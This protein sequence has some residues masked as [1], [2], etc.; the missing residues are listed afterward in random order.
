[1]HTYKNV[2]ERVNAINFAEELASVYFDRS[3]IPICTFSL[4]L[5]CILHKGV[6]YK[7]FSCCLSTSNDLIVVQKGSTLKSIQEFNGWAYFFSGPSFN[8]T[9]H[10]TKK[11]LSQQIFGS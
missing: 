5:G 8:F 4:I 6:F 1:M 7:D 9:Q 10:R 2:K 3:V 11:I